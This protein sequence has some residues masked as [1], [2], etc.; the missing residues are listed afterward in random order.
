MLEK[1]L[2]FSQEEF[3]A[4]QGRTLQ[5][6]QKYGLD[7]LLIFSQE[8]MFY[9]TGY[10]TFGYV[11]FQC[12]YLRGDGRM[13]LLTRA[14]DL[15]QAQ[16]TSVIEDIRI[17]KDGPNANPAD[18]LRAI[19]DEQGGANRLGVEWETYGLTAGNG[20][21]VAAAFARITL[22]DASQLISKLRVIKSDSEL[23]Y[24]FR[25]AEL[26]DAGLAAAVNLAKPA[27]F[28]GDILAAMQG[29]IFRGGGDYSGNEFIIGSGQRALLCRS[30]SG[31]RHLA[32][33]DQLT[34]EFAGAY[35]HYH[36]ALMRTLIIGKPEPQHTA[37]YAVCKEARAR[38]I[39]ALHPGEPI[40]KVFDA[41]AEVV[42]KAGMK[43]HRFNATGYSLGAKFAPSWMDWPM[44]YHGNPVIAQ[45]NMVFF[46]HIILMDS[47]VGV[48]M[49]TGETLL[50]TD[51]GARSLSSA[52][53]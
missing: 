47:D 15:R 9:L 44:F 19:V 27:A 49:S 17:W 30:F 20:Q 51:S 46:L 12:L 39:E 50:V 11:F 24:V 23:K 34:L 43:R 7:G 53:R 13:T 52:P 48:A 26:A 8:S 2:H 21:R 4:R 41:Y 33:N 45:P 18:E 37:M 5:M 31:R 42:D 28:E 29:A 36:A 14:P 40:G 38:G 10:D 6:M 22:E 16:M 32:E 3:S 35:R 1:Q 25:A